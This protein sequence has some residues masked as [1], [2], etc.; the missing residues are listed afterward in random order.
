MNNWI[1]LE[2]KTKLMKMSKT[3]LML[4]KKNLKNSI[5]L[6][7]S[8]VYQLNIQRTKN[9]QDQQ[10]FVTDKKRQNIF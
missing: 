5:I 2:K 4:S 6:Y 3:S 9:L 8:Q 1:K 7:K 10:I